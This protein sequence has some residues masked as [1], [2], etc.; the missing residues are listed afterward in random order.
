MMKRYMIC[1][2]ALLTAIALT[3]CGIAPN[4]ANNTESAAGNAA[5]ADSDVDKIILPTDEG[6]IVDEEVTSDNLPEFID[7][8]QYKGYAIEAGPDVPIE[9]GL[10]V[11]L[12]YK[13]SIGGKDVE[14]V[15]A[16]GLELLIGMNDVVAGFDEALIGHKEG[17]EFS[18]DLKIPEDYPDD[19][20]SG[21]TVTY[22][23]AIRKVYL[24]SPDIAYGQF[25]DSCKVKKYPRS[26]FDSWSRLYLNN[27]ADYTGPD[28]KAP[29][30]EEVLGM[31]GMSEEM[32]DD[33]MKG[34]VK[35]ILAID[36]VFREEQ[37]DRESDEYLKLMSEYL[38]KGGYRSFDEA[39]SKGLPAEYITYCVDVRMMEE[40]LVRYEEK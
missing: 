32:F 33:M 14:G 7:V 31:M 2:A 39:V 5:A 8:G 9:E 6:E 24:E 3:G 17:E 35:E 25:M 30:R 40:I 38:K 19:A 4:T 13:A 23:A 36:A 28:D 27:Y 20:I 10:T 12:D 26:L 16:N 22:D 37:I 21:K 34:V 18:F 15:A 1:T 29:S 11:V